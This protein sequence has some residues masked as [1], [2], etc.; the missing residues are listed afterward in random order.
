MVHKAKKIRDKGKLKL[1]SYFKK[2][3]DN[4]NVA[5]VKDT[6]VPS[7]FPDRIQGLS[8]KVVRSRG[9]YKDVLIKDGNKEKLFIIHPVHL[10]LL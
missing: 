5:I 7:S 10:K 8:G 9:K 4:S 2:I 6:G 3:D 1:S